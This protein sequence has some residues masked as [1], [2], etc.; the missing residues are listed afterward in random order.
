MVYPP[1]EEYNYYHYKNG[2]KA[3][4]EFDPVSK[5]AFFTSLITLIASVIVLI[6]KLS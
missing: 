2:F 4:G 5:I 3:W 6:W 1:D